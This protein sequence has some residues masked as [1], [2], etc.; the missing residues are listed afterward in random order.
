MAVNGDAAVER[1]SNYISYD[2]HFLHRLLLQADPQYILILLIGTAEGKGGGGGG[3]DYNRQSVVNVHFLPA[4][5]GKEFD[6]VLS[7]LVVHHLPLVMEIYEA[8]EQYCTFQQ[9]IQ[10]DGEV[11]DAT[12]EIQEIIAYLNFFNKHVPDIYGKFQ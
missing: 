5:F 2:E 12:E 10:K 6:N 9:P 3:G 8:R 7:S 4:L 1:P 11:L